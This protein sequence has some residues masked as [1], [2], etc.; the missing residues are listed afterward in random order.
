MERYKAL[1]IKDLRHAWKDPVLMAAMLGPLALLFVSRF[2][3]PVAID[4]LDINYSFHLEPYRGFAGSLLVVTIPM[5]TGMLTGLL[6]LDERDENMIAYYAVT[7]LMRQGYL[8]YRVTFPFMLCTVLSLVYLSFSTLSDIH[9]DKLGVLLLLA[10]EAP[11]FSLFL[12]AFS[13]NKVEGLALSK[14]GGL[15]IAGPVVANFVPGAWQVLGAW[16]PTY[17]PAK[18]PYLITQNEP[19]LA[20]VFF[21]VGLLLHA[22]YLYF[23]VSVFNNRQ[24]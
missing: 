2:G 1:I 19:I 20:I 7:P 21:L 14:I 22:A 17:W 6:M 23:M 18:I 5:L 13:A 15:F 10:L 24:S 11:L 16:L 12:A 4:W 9:W 8:L 3:F